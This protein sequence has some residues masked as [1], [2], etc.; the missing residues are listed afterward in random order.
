M[1]DNNWKI[2]LNCRGTKFFGAIVHAGCYFNCETKYMNLSDNTTVV[3][4]GFLNLPNLEKLSIVE[5][6][7]EY[8]D[9]NDRDPIR[10]ENEVKLQELLTSSPNRTCVCCGRSATDQT[11]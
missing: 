4:H 5:A 9:S 11:L 1:L 10:A 3:L 2:S 6:I 7:N 8:F